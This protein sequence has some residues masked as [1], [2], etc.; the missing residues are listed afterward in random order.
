MSRRLSRRE[1]FD[2]V[3]DRP[4]TKVAADLGVS[5]VAIH[6]ICRKHEIPVPGRGH[7]AKV[8]AGKPVKAG[9]LQEIDDARLER[10][11]IYGNPAADMPAPIRKVREEA[12]G[13]KTR[14]GNAIKVVD[15]PVDLHPKVI[16]TRTKLENAKPDE[17][18]LVKAAGPTFFNV[19]VGPE[20]I[21]RVTAFLDALVKASQA[22]GYRILKAK[23]A[24]AFSVDEE[25][26]E[27]KIVELTERS[28]HEPTP[29]ELA[30]IE[31]WE[32]KQRAHYQSWEIL[33]WRR[34]TP[35]EWDYAPCGM[36]KVVINEDHYSCYGL[37]KTFADGKTQ[38][39]ETLINVVLA[40]FAAWSAGIKAKRLEDER[41]RLEWAAEEHRRE[42]QQLRDAL[43]Q[44]RIKALTRDLER[45]QQR[46]RILDYVSIV[47]ERLV[48]GNDPDP[49]AT[50]EWIAW[51]LDYADRI[52]PLCKGLPRLLQM[53]DFNEWELRHR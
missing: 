12:R 11:E 8:A 4:V 51:A 22:R 15:H 10:I 36:L 9:V 5:D 45:W 46:Q 21:E 1:L 39:I 53:E 40:E 6:K 17:R 47:K 33:D 43:E 14:P 49:D 25:L 20:S 50:S 2:M 26:L 18:G 23:T 19:E 31:K 32:S 41:R 42:E 28:K 44:K 3:W 52:D 30:A 38:T 34:P 29:A 27:F 13:R 24:L 48:G 16:K 35:P 7:W 37:R